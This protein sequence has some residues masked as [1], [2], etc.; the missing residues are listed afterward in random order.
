VIVADQV[1]LVVPHTTASLIFGKGGEHVSWIQK[2]SSAHV[3]MLQNSEE[4]PSHERIIAVQGEQ[5]ELLLVQ[6]LANV[7]YIHCVSE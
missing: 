2:E 4:V 1:K 5:R 6:L 3:H 7:Q